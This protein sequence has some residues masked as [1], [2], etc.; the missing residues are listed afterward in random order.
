MLKSNHKTLR[1][2]YF[3]C[4]IISWV[5]LN[6]LLCIPK[7]GIAQ[8]KVQLVCTDNALHKAQNIYAA[9]TFNKW[10]PNHL[11][12]LFTKTDKHTYSLFL[13]NIKP[14]LLQFKCTQGSWSTVEDSLYGLEKT[15]RLIEINSDTTIYFSIDSWRQHAIQVAHTASANV[16]LLPDSF[17]IPTLNRYR[18]IWVYLPANYYKA[19]LHYP[20]LY[21][22]DGQNLFDN[23]YAAFGEWGVDEALDSLQMQQK[24]YAIVVGINHGDVKRIQEYNPYD[25][26]TYGVGEGEAFTNFLMNTI[27]PFIDKNYR[28]K[29]EPKYTAIAGSSLGALIST[30]AIVKHPHL[31]GT[32]GIFSPAYWIAPKLKST[33][34]TYK[35]VKRKRQMWLYAGGKESQRMIPDLTLIKNLLAY[36]KYNYVCLAIDENEQH[37]EKAWR[38]WFPSFYTF[39]AKSF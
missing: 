6:M 28:T 3:F 25:T 34:A 38:K 14:G 29:P 33:I 23:Y 36:N 26:D 19:K 20:V 13:H 8:Y 27:K 21:M 32:A 11:Q 4:K 22:Q 18:K 17:F 30:Y 5:I 15:N 7:L 1:P 12:Y 10:L 31:Y 2:I 35:N 16:I 39:W 24:K 9:G 37:N